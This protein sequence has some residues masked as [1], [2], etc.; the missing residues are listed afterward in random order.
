[1]FIR[2]SCK[3]FNEYF[4]CSNPKVKRSLFGFGPRMCVYEI[5][6]V[7]CQ[8]MELKERP[9]HIPHPPPLRPKVIFKHEGNF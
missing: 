1:M 6:R 3:F 4:R 5:D 2:P 8:Y 7:Y 9:R